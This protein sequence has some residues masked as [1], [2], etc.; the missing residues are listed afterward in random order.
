M[1]K[2]HTNLSNKLYIFLSEMIVRLETTQW[3][4]SQTKS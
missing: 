1:S 3:T 4:T 2:K